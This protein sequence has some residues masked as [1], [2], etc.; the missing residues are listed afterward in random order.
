MVT[1]YSKNFETVH[2]KVGDELGD[3]VGDGVGDDLTDNQKKIV[4]Y[5]LANR[6]I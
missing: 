6:T 2:H 3:G 5:L 1:V 4:E